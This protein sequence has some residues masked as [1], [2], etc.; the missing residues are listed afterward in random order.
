[1]YRTFGTACR[2]LRP[3]ATAIFAL[4]LAGCAN[5]SSVYRNQTVVDTFGGRQSIVITDAKQ[6]AIH[7]IQHGSG[8]NAKLKLCAEQAPDIFSVLSATASG[9]L[10][11]K[12]E[13]KELA[14][15]AAAALAE[16]GGAIERSQTVNILAM[17]M[18]RTCERFL[19]GEIGGT[20]LSWQAARD[21][22]VMVSVLA[23][24]QLTNMIRPQI[25]PT[26]SLGAGYVGS[27][28]AAYTERL[29]AARAKWEKADK[30]KDTAQAAHTAALTAAQLPTGKNCSDIQ[31]PADKDACAAKEETLKQATSSAKDARDYYDAILKS[32]DALQMEVKGATVTSE[33]SANIV[34]NVDTAAI[35]I[36]AEHVYKLAMRGS[37]INYDQEACLRARSERMNLAKN[38]QNAPSTYLDQIESLFCLSGTLKESATVL[39]SANDEKTL[40]PIQQRGQGTQNIDPIRIQT[41]IA[42]YPQVSNDSQREYLDNLLKSKSSGISN[43]TFYRTEKIPGY[44][45]KNILRY[46]HSNDKANCNDLS[47]F[48]IA[49]L[50]TEVN[51]IYV[52][53]YEEK[54]VPGQ[55]EIWIGPGTIIPKN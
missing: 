42:V 25:R 15:K 26:A 19:N 47:R 13:Q 49:T 11:V 5:W 1:M 9:E 50:D 53:G 23:I 29:A 10:A 36:I 28:A 3:G 2:A 14:A 39:S 37:E 51:C 22:R 27:M 24:E 33:K 38:I 8:A 41:K 52:R 35:G 54:V 40:T 46:F 17:S 31:T 48:L 21:Q 55:M 16:S 43:T 32:S 44:S 34:V 12:P 4:S 7:Y 20:E 30:A 18:Y 6:R 45:G